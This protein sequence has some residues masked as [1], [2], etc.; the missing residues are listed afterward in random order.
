MY[1]LNP[2]E[3]LF[4]FYTK[5]GQ[6]L[7]RTLELSDMTDRNISENKELFEG[8]DKIISALDMLAM[9]SNDNSLKDSLTYLGSLIVSTKSTDIKVAFD[10]CSTVKQ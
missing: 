9:E 10:Y 4:V 6:K 5:L 3:F 1:E 8:K 2:N 7:K